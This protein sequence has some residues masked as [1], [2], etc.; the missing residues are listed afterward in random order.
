MYPTSGS[1]L[2]ADINLKVE[3]AAS[4]DRFFVGH[5]VMPALGVDAKSG[6][7]PKVKIA[8]AELLSA[9]ATIRERTGSYG[10][11]SRQWTNDT[12][13]C[14]DRGLEEPVDDTDQKDLARFFNVEASA[15]RWCLRNLRLDHEVRVQTATINTTNYG[16]ATN[17]SVAYTE[18]NLA[19]I[20]FPSDAL[21]AIDRVED[22]GHMPNTILIPKAVFTRLSL[23][24]KLQN[25]IRGTLRGSVEVPVNAQTVAQSFADHGITQVLIGRAR[26]NSAKKGQA[27]SATQVWPNSHIWIGYVNPDA[28]TPQDGGSGFTFVW[29]AEGGLWVTESYRNEQRRSNLV[30]V[31]QHTA[32]KVTDG[33]AGTLIAT[34]Y[35]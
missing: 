18:A 27:Y 11:A 1:T 14:I 8:E 10:E 30:R 31:R 26:Y 28:R 29:N 2:R 35:A 23:S 4:A 3:E 32:E 20:D 6:Q 16:A 12:Y 17:S 34:Q 15:A 19:T 33:T 25:W 13:D 9:G 22:K 24:A 7:Y 5:L 21:K